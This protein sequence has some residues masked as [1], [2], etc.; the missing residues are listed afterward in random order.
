MKGSV[1][2]RKSLLKK[3]ET[4]EILGDYELCGFREGQ[5]NRFVGYVRGLY[6]LDG[7]FP[8]RWRLS[9]RNNYN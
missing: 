5:Y 4:V 3:L 1:N 6:N 9:A 8:E 2:I 7:G